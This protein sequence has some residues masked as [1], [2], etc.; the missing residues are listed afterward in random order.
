MSSTLRS[1]AGS[2]PR[3]PSPPTPEGA[4]AGDPFGALVDEA[5]MRVF[6]VDYP[7]IVDQLVELFVYSTPPLLQELR[8]RRRE[9]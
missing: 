1:S 2:A 7:E 3:P 6:R 9:R 8:V 5:R 4:P